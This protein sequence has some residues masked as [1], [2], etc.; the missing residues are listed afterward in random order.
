MPQPKS[1]RITRSPGAVSTMM[2]IAWRMSSSYSA[3]ATNP[4]TGSSATGMAQPRP[5]NSLFWSA[6]MRSPDENV[7]RAHRD[8]VRRPHLDDLV[9]LARGRKSADQHRGAA[10]RHHSADVRLHA[11][12]ERANV[13][14]RR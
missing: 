2:R 1:G 10:H 7:G 5:R 12:H 8:G 9:A 13:R 14:I 6:A 4:V 3:K 11:V